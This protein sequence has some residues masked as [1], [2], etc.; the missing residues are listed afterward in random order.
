[1]H[2]DS[3]VLLLLFV[4]YHSIFSF[5]STFNLHAFFLFFNVFLLSKQVKYDFVKFHDDYR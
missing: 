2:V 1:M 5:F 4:E 3:T